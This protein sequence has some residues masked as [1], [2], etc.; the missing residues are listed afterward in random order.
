[1]RLADIDG[2]AVR[3]ALGDVGP[4]FQTKD[5]SERRVMHDAHSP[6]EPSYHS[7]VGRYLS[8]NRAEL[9]LELAR[10]DAGK[11]GACWRKLR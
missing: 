3:V 4:V 5:L 10:A 7:L 1:M 8:R 9:Q 2:H 11:K 6:I